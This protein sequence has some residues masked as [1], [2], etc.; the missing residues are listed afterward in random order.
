MPARRKSAP[1]TAAGT[2]AKPQGSKRSIKPG[3]QDNSD[4][5]P[6]TTRSRRKDGSENQEREL[7]VED[8]DSNFDDE[9]EELILRYV[10][11]LQNGRASYRIRMPNLWTNCLP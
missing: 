8:D 3:A 4:P 5:E 11:H 9:D 7:H 1:V 6:T 2:A 10:I